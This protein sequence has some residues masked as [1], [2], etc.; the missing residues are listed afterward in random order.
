M[1]VEDELAA[2]KEEVRALREEVAQLRGDLAPPQP[3][4]H[5]AYQWREVTRGGD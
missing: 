4:A 5:P 3:G 1:A 2:L